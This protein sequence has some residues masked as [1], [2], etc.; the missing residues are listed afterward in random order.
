MLAVGNRLGAEARREVIGQGVAEA[1]I[2]VHVRAHVRYAGTD[3]ALVVPAYTLAGAATEPAA[4]PALA[5]LK[6]AFE[7][8]HRARF[9]FIDDTKTLVIE[10]IS[11]E[12]IGGGAK[13]SEP[14]LP[15]TTA[16]LPAPRPARRSSSPAAPGATAA[17]YLREELAPGHKVPGP[18]IIIEPHQ[19]IVVEDGWQA[20]ITAKNHLLL[21]ARGAAAA[22]PRHRHRRRSGD[23]R[24]LQQPLHVDRRAD[25]RRAAEHRLLRQHQ[26]AAR[27]LLRRVRP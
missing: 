20:E 2:T 10:A 3:T 17:V 8:A 25:G 7:T 23:A 14:A 9:G 16:P 21:D 11:V 24:G 15:L 18:A 6:A 27:L 22:Q 19:T 1:D 13:F 4:P 12:A 5:A 26:G